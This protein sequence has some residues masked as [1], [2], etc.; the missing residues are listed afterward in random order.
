M[1][2]KKIHPSL[3]NICFLPGFQEFSLQEHFSTYPVKSL[4]LN[5]AALA[6]TGAKGSLG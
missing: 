3:R 5:S 6:G 2:E 1:E 4:V